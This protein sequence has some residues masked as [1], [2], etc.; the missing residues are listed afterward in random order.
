MMR[1]RAGQR[2]PAGWR[3]TARATSVFSALLASD[4]HPRGN[5]KRR[6]GP[7]GE[8]QK[9]GGQLHGVVPDAEFRKEE[10]ALQL[11]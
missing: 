5:S 6:R 3:R 11:P 9:A 2:G 7:A 10:T 1:E 4:R 8:T